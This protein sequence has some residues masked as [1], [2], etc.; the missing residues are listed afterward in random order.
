MSESTEVVYGLHAVRH[1][2]SQSAYKV[3]EIWVQE[4]KQESKNIKTLLA[5]AGSI[6]VQSVPKQT[7]DKLAEFGRHQGIA[8]RQQKHP[9]GLRVN[10]EDLLVD[11]YKSNPLF[12]VLDGVQDPHNLGACLRTADAAGVEAV[13]LPRDRA[14]GV[15]ASVRKVASGAAE[16]LPILEVTNLARTLRQIRDAGVWVVG[17]SDRAE[18]TIYQ[19]DLDRPLALVMGAEGMGIRENTRKQCDAIVRL[20]MQGTVESLNVSVATGICLF[21]VLRQRL[22]LG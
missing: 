21:E 22:A 13:I 8:L 15:T 6:P 3:I 1:V 11:A 20:P 12:L 5:S 10:L 2:L 14:V 16:N 4:G 19:L 7:L 9:P 17:T 18:Q